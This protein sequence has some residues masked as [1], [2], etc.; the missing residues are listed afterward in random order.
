MV[1]AYILL[2]SN[3]DNPVCHIKR[4]V[5]EIAALDEV[6]LLKHSRLY[7]SAPMG[8]PDQPDFI[9]AVIQV[10]TH[11]PAEVLLSQLLLLE[12]IHGRVHTRHWGERT[13]DCDM[14]MYGNLSCET[15]RLTLPHPRM[16]ERPFVL[17]P[18]LEI[19]PQVTLPNGQ[20][21]CDSHRTDLNACVLLEGVFN[22]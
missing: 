21:V 18:L 13:L 17:R 8:P 20:K 9:N 19:D 14:L 4:A 12:E 22:D 7:Q 3:V 2:G 16:L 6:I 1:D 10:R 5:K 11:I 15:A